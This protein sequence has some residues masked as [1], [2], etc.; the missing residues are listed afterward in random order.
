[1]N[2]TASCK[3]PTLIQNPVLNQSLYNSPSLVPTQ[4]QKNAVH[5]L[6]N[7]FFKIHFNIIIS[8]NDYDFQKVTSLKDCNPNLKAIWH[9]KHNT[10]QEIVNCNF[11]ISFL[12]Q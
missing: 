12:G 1:M 8:I 2:Q 7:Y 5:I 10:K 6:Q 9:P 4:S 11:T 3:F